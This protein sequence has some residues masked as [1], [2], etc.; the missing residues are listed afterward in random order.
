V[1]YAADTAVV[2]QC[3][4]C[5]RGRTPNCPTPTEPAGQRPGCQACGE[6]W[7]FPKQDNERTGTRNKPHCMSPTPVPPATAFKWYA[8]ATRLATRSRSTAGKREAPIYMWAAWSSLPF[9]HCTSLHKLRPFLFGWNIIRVNCTCQTAKCHLQ[10]WERG[11]GAPGR[12]VR[13]PL[14]STQLKGNR[15]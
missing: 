8:L 14:C 5:G 2:G 1:R 12:R 15:R 11:R 10:H 7:G 3:L 13:A 9:Q 6:M 4:K